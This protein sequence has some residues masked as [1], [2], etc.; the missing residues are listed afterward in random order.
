MDTAGLLSGVQ[1]NSLLLG[2]GAVVFY[3]WKARQ[4]E[5]A[6]VMVD[7][8]DKHMTPRERLEAEIQASAELRAEIA[9]DSEVSQSRHRNTAAERPDL[10]VPPRVGRRHDPRIHEHIIAQFGGK[11][12][13]G[14]LPGQLAI[15]K[16]RAGTPEGASMRSVGR[17]SV[18][19]HLA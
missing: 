5:A 8:T 6:S 2:V 7:A 11:P 3:T 12:R 19:A 16:F 9:P 13:T 10:V 1:R 15:D 14:R 17:D 4:A 18:E